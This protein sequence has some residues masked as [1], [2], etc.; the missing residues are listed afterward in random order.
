MVLL[1]LMVISTAS[2]LASL[3]ILRPLLTAFEYLTMAITGLFRLA[4]PP[5]PLS[6]DRDSLCRVTTDN[7]MALKVTS[8]LLL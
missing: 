1:H 8:C 5:Y 2:L 7:Q 3:P 6:Q 4:A